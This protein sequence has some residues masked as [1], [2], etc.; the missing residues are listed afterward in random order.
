MDIGEVAKKSGLSASA[1]RYYEEIG[2][3]KSHDRHGLRRQYPSN[4]L[5][6]LAMIALAK[7]AGFQLEELFQLF[8]KRDGVI[9]IERGQLKRKASD[10]ARK[11]KRMEAARKGLIHASECRAQKHIECPKF[12]RLLAMATKRQQKKKKLN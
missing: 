12:R 2:L 5:D 3:I 6:I 7:E 9:T 10:I 4:V 11:I 1:L 8:I